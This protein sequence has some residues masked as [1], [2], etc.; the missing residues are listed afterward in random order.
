MEVR[1]DSEINTCRGKI[2]QKK[3]GGLNYLLDLF[4]PFCTLLCSERGGEKSQI[5]RK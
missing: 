3:A 5:A 2:N 1:E 4:F